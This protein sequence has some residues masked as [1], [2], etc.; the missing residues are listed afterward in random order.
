MEFHKKLGVSEEYFNQVGKMELPMPATYI[1][2]RT[3]VIRFHHIETNAALR[4]PPDDIVKFVKTFNAQ[5]V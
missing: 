1:I 4:L 3:G 2:D 5:P